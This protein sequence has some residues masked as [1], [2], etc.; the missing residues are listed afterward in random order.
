[1][2]GDGPPCAGGDT[3]LAKL[4][5]LD[6]L[7]VAVN[8]KLYESNSLKQILTDTL[9]AAEYSDPHTEEWLGHQ[10]THQRSHLTGMRLMT[11][12][13]QCKFND[14]ETTK[15]YLEYMADNN[16]DVAVIQEPFAKALPDLP[17]RI[18]NLGR[19]YECLIKFTIDNARRSE[20]NLII[21]RGAWRG[22]WANTRAIT[23]KGFSPARLARTTFKAAKKRQRGTP[24]ERVAVYSI[25]GYADKSEEEEMAK[26]IQAMR[27]DIRNYRRTNPFTTIIVAGDVNATWKTLLDTDR[28]LGDED[29][30]RAAMGDEPEESDASVIKTILDT[31][32]LY[33]TFREIHPNTQRFTRCAPNQVS[34]TLDYIFMTTEAAHHPATRIGIHTSSPLPGDHYQVIADIPLDCTATIDGVTPLWQPYKA[35]PSLQ[36]IQNPTT[37]QQQEYSQKVSDLL[38]EYD[39]AASLEAQGEVIQKALREAAIGTVAKLIHPR[40]PRPATRSPHRDGFGHRLDTWAKRIRGAIRAI[41]KAAPHQILTAITK[42]SWDHS[43][44]PSTLNKDTL[45]DTPQLWL[46]G[47]RQTVR[48]RLVDQHEHIQKHE[49]K[50]RQDIKAANIKAARKRRND[51]FYDPTG[52][53]KGRV[54]SNI[55]R[56]IRE[57]ETLQWVRDGKGELHTSPEAVKETVG[58]F[59]ENWMKS[60]VPVEER[61]G[62]W[63]AMM[64]L[65]TSH[66]SNP[67]FKDMIK[68][69]YEK[70]RQ[71][72]RRRASSENWYVDLLIEITMEELKAAIK[73]S[74]AKSASGPSQIG[75]AALQMLDDTALAPILELFNT[76]LKTKAIPDCLNT[77]LM[78][79]LPK[80][81]S[82]LD[83]L[84]KVRPIVLMEC[85]T[86]VY[87]RIVIGRVV[88]AI[89]KHQI[90]DVGQY[91]GYQAQAFRPH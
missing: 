27:K 54:I 48:Q 40:Y 33:D 57:F 71:E 83:D 15:L 87:E 19:K 9:P 26:L 43:E 4:S 91:G 86:K 68:Q 46:G 51:S 37:E 2:Q 75:N 63:Q 31:T 88:R 41:D 38:K 59:F 58:T 14:E 80:S 23:G 30:C 77:A 3:E 52:A 44:F 18:R 13:A 25:Y 81:D 24:L 70:P 84:N 42:A 53:G 10:F 66:M 47:N 1:M 16:V 49:K 39:P 11:S 74:P 8:D 20:G 29:A 17:A 45:I 73:D 21:M 67:A 56:T 50:A 36:W 5:T 60:R 89:V 82:G 6:S 79:L 55:F 35:P 76:C 34:R 7:N 72:N 90:L 69:A 28:I 64:E 12:N 32:P 85:L 62:S 78:K 22:V 61:W 65:D